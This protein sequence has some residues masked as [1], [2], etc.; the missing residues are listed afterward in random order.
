M[1]HSLTVMPL[2]VALVVGI[3][4]M[5]LNIY[6]IHAHNVGTL[7]VEPWRSRTSSIARTVRTAFAWMRS[8]FASRALRVSMA[9][10]LAL[11]AAHV[12]DAAG[13]GLLIAGVAGSLEMPK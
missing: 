1:N 8:L 5:G 9:V 11:L 12:N 13:H 4:G 7:E 3:A 6:D 10:A 2:L